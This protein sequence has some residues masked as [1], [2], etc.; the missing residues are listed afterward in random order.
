VS[1]D[2]YGAHQNTPE[3]DSADFSLT[4]EEVAKGEQAAAAYIESLKAGDGRR[5]AE[6]ALRT[7]ATVI[8]GGVCDDLHFPWH[9]VR[10]YHGALALS[11]VKERG[12]PT[13]VELLRCRHDDTRKFQQVPETYPTKHVQKMRVSLRGVMQAARSLGFI[14]EEDL[15]QALLPGKSNGQKGKPN[16]DRVL[17]EGEV[18]ALLSACD[19]DSGVRGCRDALIVGLAWFGGLK[20]VD[21]INLTVG[22][23]DFDQKQGRMTIKVKQ[24]GA[25]RSRRIPLENDELI[26][27]ED[28][29][30]L[31]GR[32]EGP[33]FCP[34]ARGR[35]ETRRLSAADVKKLCDERGEQ[36]GVLPYSPNDLCKSGPL[37]AEASKRRRNG[38]G[39]PPAEPEPAISPLYSSRAPEP[40]GT[41]RITF[42]YRVRIGN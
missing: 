41:K 32:E 11:I 24:P 37:G 5:T 16:R 9:Q 38:S 19:M 10:A 25:K 31:R 22:N 8:S 2:A 29:L 23:L 26:A 42:P 36:A 1:A 35:V 17:T 14:D 39:Q 13:K 21:L 12:A 34:V 20:T 30:E 27:L 28:W 18:R 33:L 4:P 7:L 6:D 40:T 3:E 15:D